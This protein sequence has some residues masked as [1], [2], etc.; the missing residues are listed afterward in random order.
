M[1]C[2]QA[3]IVVARV[4]ELSFRNPAWSATCEDTDKGLIAIQQK[5]EYWR[6]F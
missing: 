4:N 3:Y 1:N 6:L 5:N 2:K